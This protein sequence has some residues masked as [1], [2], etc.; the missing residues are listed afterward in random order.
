MTAIATVRAVRTPR[1]QVLRALRL[2]AIVALVLITS[3]ILIHALLLLLAHRALADER[4]ACV[5]AGVDLRPT[6]EAPSQLQGP[7]PEESLRIYTLLARDAGYLRNGRFIPAHDVARV[8]V[9][10]TER[11]I[12]PTAWTSKERDKVTL[13]LARIGPALDL[14]AIEAQR[15]SS[16]DIIFGSGSQALWPNLTLARLL[17]VRGVVEADA[18]SM[19]TALRDFVTALRLGRHLQHAGDITAYRLGGEL[20]LLVLTCLQPIA[21]RLG[22]PS[23]DLLEALKPDGP[24]DLAGMVDREIVREYDWVFASRKGSYMLDA[25]VAIPA[26]GGWTLSNWVQAAYATPLGL[27][28]RLH[29]EA[30]WLRQ[31]RA[32]RTWLHAPALSAERASIERTLHEPP[33]WALVSR[34]FRIDPEAALMLE[35]SVELQQRCESVARSAFTLL[36]THA[37]TGVWPQDPATFLPSGPYHLAAVDDGFVLSAENVPNLFSDHAPLRWHLGAGGELP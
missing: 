31:V 33:V 37:E 15:P 16:I 19:N 4:A 17:V 2:V 27:P 12:D 30:V 28:L 11:R 29:D 1:A 18:G 32:A 21:R 5:A 10:G 23:D 36:Q 34:T 22:C 7:T 14:A 20:R 24:Q 26:R 13:T 25:I 6:A 3:A 8:A 9:L 35:R